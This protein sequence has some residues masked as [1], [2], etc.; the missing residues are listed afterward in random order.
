VRKTIA[1]VLSLSLIFSLFSFVL[2]AREEHV[3]AEPLVVP[4][5]QKDDL[6][7]ME[8]LSPGKP[9]GSV[10]YAAASLPKTFNGLIA[11]ETSSTDVTDEIM[12]SG[13]TAV[14]PANGKTVPAF[15]KSWE[16]SEDKKTYTFHLRKGLKFSD[17]K[18]LTADDVIFTY[19]NLI[20]NE[21]V[22]TDMRDVLKVGGELPTVEK[23][24]EDTVK[25]TTPT[26]FGPFVRQV[27]TAIYPKHL[28]GEVSV[29][30]FNSAWGRQVATESPEKIVGA[31][32]FRL[33]K[34]TPGQQVVLER[35]PYYYKVD[36]E[37]TQLP[38]LDSYV[39]LK[40]EDLDVSLLKF[41]NHETDVLNARAQDIP[42]LLRNAEREDWNVIINK[43]PS[44]APA[45]TDFLTFNW[46]AKK[47]ALADV[48]SEAKFRR[49]VSHAINRSEM[50]DIIFNGLAIAQDSPISQLSPYYNPEA[51]QVYPKEYDPEQ[52]RKLLNE[53]GLKDT[54]DDGVRELPDGKDLSFE[55][56]TNKGNT[57]RV[58]IGN[59]IMNDLKQVGIDMQLNPIDFNSLVQ[60]LLSGEYQGVI[61]GLIGDPIEP[62]S[63]ANTQKSTGGLHFWHFGAK[64]NPT[65]A[66]KR[67]DELFKQGV[68]NIGVE[69][70]R[71]Y[72]D[73]FQT[74][75]AETVPVIYTAAEVY[76]YAHGES[77]QNTAT[78]SPL[79]SFLG[80]CEYVWK[81]Q[82]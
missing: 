22:D 58:D 21:K 32:P 10:T 36:A 69:D 34:F 6:W 54:D 28:L 52:T 49:A 45:G 63:M 59:M 26:V 44:G 67:I 7:E 12:G 65:E 73:E 42:F 11:D 41:K 24:D 40:V 18:P 33:K 80:H 79:G 51:G 77:V 25:F 35:N 20:F 19:K 61:I 16:I 66:E 56:M 48:F 55:V 62:N 76:L 47:E 31:G 13:L 29:E 43:G 38:Y 14:N 64:E 9:G 82:D 1:V 5:G 60:R 23:V 4:I 39:V 57:Q 78:F 2:L 3:P 75:F 46:D 81:V 72:Y 68:Q 17:G 74:V 27:S 70:R 50:I 8:E 37:G 53:L 71:P 15:A 30:K